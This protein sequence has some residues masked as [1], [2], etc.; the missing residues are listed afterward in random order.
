MSQFVQK[1]SFED[2]FFFPYE[3][4]IVDNLDKYPNTIIFNTYFPTKLKL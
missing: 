3:N 1:S 4:L 2:K